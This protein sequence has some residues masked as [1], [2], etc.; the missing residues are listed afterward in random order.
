M[1]RYSTK[2]IGARRPPSI[3]LAL[4]LATLAAAQD[5]PPPVGGFSVAETLSLPLGFAD[6]YR[7]YVDLRYPDPAAVAPPATGWPA[8]LLVPSW[9]DS[10]RGQRLPAIEFAGR[11]YVTISYDVRGQG[12]TPGLNPTGGGTIVGGLEKGDMVEVLQFAAARLGPLLDFARLAVRGTS[13]GA[14][15]SWAAA[16]WSGKPLLAAR[17]AHTHFPVI[18]AVSPGAFNPDMAE[19]IAPG[20]GAAFSGRMILKW[21]RPGPLLEPAFLAAGRQAFLNQDFTAWRAAIYT[22]WRDDPDLIVDSTVAVYA[23]NAWYDWWA[24]VNPMAAAINRMPAA[25]PRLVH[26]S[27]G[28]HGSPLNDLERATREEQERRWFDHLL[29]GRADEIARLPR[30][31]LS[32]PPADPAEYL[33]IGSAWQTRHYAQFP[34]TGA[35]A[36]KVF[37]LAAEENL[38]STAPAGAEATDRIRHR[39]PAG[40][41]PT[42]WLQTNN[43]A[44]AVLADIPLDTVAYRSS[45]VTVETELV[46]VPTLDVHIDS[47]AANLQLHAVLFD[48][49]PSGAR[50]WITDGFA[51][52]RG[53][54]GGP[55]QLSIDFAAMQYQ[56]PIGHRW[57]LV[58]ENHTYR[59]PPGRT[60]M[61]TVPYFES[62]DIEVAH[63]AAR[64]SRLVLPLRAA[65]FSGRAAVARLPISTGGSIDIGVRGA[66]SRGGL[67]YAALVSASGTVPGI[68]LF[69]TQVPINFDP[70]TA[71]GLSGGGLVRGFVG[72]LDAT[73]RGDAQLTLPPGLAP[74]SAVGSVL[75]F[76][77]IALNNASS[78][79]A[80]AASDVHLVW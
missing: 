72:V 30:F 69:G 41:G 63:D 46:G 70:L 17:G 78:I 15:H 6:G 61:H 44:S 65:G 60:D 35:T 12:D 49:S 14:S 19:T 71:A 10:R 66:S 13:Q 38:S 5:P 4:G 33:A 52:L 62:Y 16:A 55:Q 80:S 24:P 11:G 53:R 20:G 37:Y 76:A 40:Y 32:M 25:T 50:R 51:L 1:Q 7:T 26:V 29:K 28:E 57:L 3:A 18:T 45:A 2:R 64:P 31:Q 23:H 39:V 21:F 77:A 43:V 56:L 68:P 36:A 34:D 59:R 27:T 48:E 8:L 75:S 67:L 58:L 47:A 74:P 42:A 73:G 9:G 54:T 22:P 79:T